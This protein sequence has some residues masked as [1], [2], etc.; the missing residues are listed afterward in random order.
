MITREERKDHVK[1]REA[2]LFTQS[3]L[4]PVPGKRGE[5]HQLHEGKSSRAAGHVVVQLVG[6]GKVKENSHLT[7]RAVISA[8]CK[9]EK[10]KT[11][12]ENTKIKNHRPRG[13]GG[14]HFVTS[15]KHDNQNGQNRLRGHRNAQIERQPK[16]RL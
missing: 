5:Q 2:G 11:I 3:T 4:P 15:K 14:R 6:G 12:T 16:C 10:R 7:K 1:S 8:L 13:K 9:A